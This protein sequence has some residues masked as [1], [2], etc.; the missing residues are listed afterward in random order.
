[1]LKFRSVIFFGLLNLLAA[2]DKIPAVTFNECLKDNKTAEDVA[3]KA[4]AKD[5]GLILLSDESYV[6]YN[7]KFKAVAIVIV[8]VISIKRLGKEKFL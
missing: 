2:L 6:E 5:N 8:I 3:S 7:C 1:M 4:V